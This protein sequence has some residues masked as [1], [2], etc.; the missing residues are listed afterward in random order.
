LEADFSVELGPDDAVLEFPWTAPE[1][2]QYYDLKH[3]PEL[4]PLVD[5]ARDYKHLADFLAAVNSASSPFETAKCDAWFTSELNP[6]EEIFGAAGKFGSYV[7]VVFSGES[8]FSFSTHENLVKRWTTLLSEAPE[9][10]AAV[11]FII[12]R[13]DFKDDPRDGFYITTYTFGYGENEDSARVQWTIALKLVENAIR[14]TWAVS[15]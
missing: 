13:C 5:E 1:G 7:D 15:S 2:L 4:L 8:R 10:P 11:E 3:H 9:I 12:R 6:E 14:Q